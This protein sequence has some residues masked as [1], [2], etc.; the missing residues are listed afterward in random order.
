MTDWRHRAAC[1]GMDTKIFFPKHGDTEGSRA[2][3]KIC[4]RCDVREECY[5]WS[6]NIRAVKHG[7]FGGMTPNQRKARRREEG[8]PEPTMPSLDWFLFGEDWV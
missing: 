5:A 1:R 3:V 6:N 8:Y 2:A 7:I 4:Q